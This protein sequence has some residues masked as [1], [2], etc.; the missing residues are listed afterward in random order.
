MTSRFA[1][2][3]LAAALL[4]LGLAGCGSA[5]EDNTG[6]FTG[7]W[8]WS[9]GMRMINCPGADPFTMPLTGQ[10]IMSKGIDAPLATAVND[11]TCT[12]KLDSSGNSAI[13]RMGQICPPTNGAFGDGTPYTET[14]TFNTG[15]FG[16]NGRVATISL[17]ASA[18][19]VSQGQT[20]VCMYSI[21]G[22]LQKQT[23]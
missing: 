2:G 5:D 22:T 14:D 23:Q 10:L 9:P 15:N 16:V 6:A 12:L 3:V 19:I 11:G 1:H 21:T 4:T 8:M 18:Q 17:S 13:L 20:A 7:S